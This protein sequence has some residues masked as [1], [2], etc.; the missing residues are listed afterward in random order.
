MAG[1]QNQNAQLQPASLNVITSNFL[2]NLSRVPNGYLDSGL[3][4]Y[5][6]TTGCNPFMKP[7]VLSFME[8]PRDITK[9][10]ITDF[11]IA[12]KERIESGVVYQYA[13]GHLGRIYKIQV[14]DAATNN[15]DYDTPVLLTTLLSTYVLASTT[16]FNAG[17][18][19][20]SSSGGVGV[21]KG[22]SGNAI[23]IQITSGTFLATNGITDTTTSNSTTITTVFA[24][25]FKFGHSIEFYSGY[26]WIG[27]DTG[28]TRVTFDGTGQ[29]PVTTSLVYSWVQN[30]PRQSQLFVGSIY[31]GNG[32][33]IA[34]VTSGLIV[35]TYTRLSPGF[36]SEYQ[37]RDLDVTADGVY[38]EMTVVRCPL[39]DITST[40]P[41]TTSI[42]AIDSEAAYWNGVNDGVTTFLSFP[43]YAQGAY[44]TFGQYEYL[45]GQDP[46][47][48]TLSTP[49]GKLL[50]LEGA[51]NPLPNAISNL[52]SLI[53]W[54]A[55]EN[56]STG[57]V[58]AL[59]AY[60]QFDQDS[61]PA[62][63][64][65]GSFSSTLED[66][67]VLKVGVMIPVSNYSKGGQNS[68][69]A[70]QIIGTGKIYFSTIE[71]DG[72]VTRY[73]FYAFSLYPTGSGTS[74]GGVYETQQQLFAKK[75]TPKEVRV[76][77]EPC[78][79]GQSFRVDLIGIDGNVLSDSSGLNTFTA[80]DARFPLGE[81]I[82]WYN[83]KV[84]PTP[85]I[86]WRITNLGTVT[87]FI[88]KVE[89][90]PVV[91]GK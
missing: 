79:E 4:R 49:Q 3:A 33:N 5:Q 53:A 76:Y 61:Q 39:E 30:V 57:L 25:T 41:D 2:G 74:I 85:A 90:D 52:G 27:H 65:L 63:F 69:Y 26:M 8:T 55:P 89:I 21:V 59:H 22:V 18:N 54:M 38:L 10:V 9:G 72:S 45:F 17:D 35:T 83:P 73:G 80:G 36:P 19:V 91:Y 20:T 34:E 12:S 84:S 67:D 37:V 47:S 78:V 60:G 81:T 46:I 86:G 15:P 24:P 71:Y 6:T 70:N 28:V 64:R 11:V 87:P 42:G 75:V 88:H 58:A 29:V 13:V 51:Q 16:G 82:A 68:G 40:S 7:T 56:L 77:L 1:E 48:A 31:F 66:G 50:T 62:H 44:A 32:T 43:N 14:N 23:T